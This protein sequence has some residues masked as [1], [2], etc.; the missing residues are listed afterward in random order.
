MHTLA[1]KTQLAKNLLKFVTKFPKDYNFY[2][3]TWILPY[4][5]ANLKQHNCN[6]YGYYIVKPEL[7]SQGDGTYLTSSPER[8]SDQER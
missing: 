8:L 6:R 2:P 3:K 4:D 5:Y 1:K 7:M